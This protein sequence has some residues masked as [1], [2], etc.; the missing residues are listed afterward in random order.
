MTIPRP[1]STDLA[2]LISH[3][4]RV[5]GDPLRIRTLDVLRDGERPVAEIAHAL[6]TSQQNASKHLGVLLQA[7][8]VSR[9]KLGT[10]AFY[11]I[12]DDTVFALCE[13]VCGGIQT[14][15]A[16]MNALI[17]GTP[18][19]KHP[20]NPATAPTTCPADRSPPARLAARTRP[21]RHG[22]HRDPHRGRPHARR[23]SL[24]RPPRRVRRRQPVGIRRFSAT[25]P[26]HSSLSRLFRLQRSV[27]S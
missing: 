17:E 27:S 6:G 8:I 25:A 1:I 20:M 15:I 16:E 7:G 4:L 21:V 14:Q 3:R 22:R 18:D 2:E 24:V 12:A 13:Q 11:A 10:S 9:R 19:P 26:R 5:I 23:E